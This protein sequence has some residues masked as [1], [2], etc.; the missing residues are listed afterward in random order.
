MLDILHTINY[1]PLAELEVGQHFYWELGSLKIHGQILL[2]SWFVIALIVLAALTATLNVQRI[3][4]GMQNFMEYILEFIRSLTK[5][6]IGEKDYRP[7]V[8]FVGTL[9]LFIFVSNWSGALVPWKVIELPAGELAAPTSDINTTV[10]LALLTSIAYFY[11]GISKKGLGYFAGYAEPVPFMVPFKIIEDF[12][13]PL[14]LSFRLFGNIL[15]DELVV[16]VLVLL[17]PL[18]IPLPLMVLGLF[19]SA[20]QALIFATLAANYIGEA[21]EEHGAEH[22]D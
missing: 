21:L 11:A 20:I 9:F 6:Q 12:T 1:L 22:H 8:P 3:P 10:A 15:A 2:T 4:S 17:V 18:F 13:K 16:G 19:L 5:D 14:S 7:W